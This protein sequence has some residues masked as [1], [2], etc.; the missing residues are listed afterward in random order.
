VPKKLL[1]AWIITSFV[2]ILIG[3]VWSRFDHDNNYAFLIYFNGIISSLLAVG[4]YSTPSNSIYGK[5]T[6][7]F[8][9]LTV[10]G[11]AFKILHLWANEM[12]VVGLLGIS[13]TYVLM[14]IR[15]HK[16]D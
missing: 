1:S 14:W 10:V 8:V 16:S 9:V 13:I 11:I 6:Y 5:I 7:G 2:A 12:I 4:Y 15:S 3:I